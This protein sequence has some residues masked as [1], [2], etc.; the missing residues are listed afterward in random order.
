MSQLAAPGVYVA[1]Q[2][3]AANSNRAANSDY[4]DSH[5]NKIEL[6]LTKLW[7]TIHFINYFHDTKAT[8]SIG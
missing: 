7:P 5:F 6:H 1:I 3:Q 8:W 2:I 4:F